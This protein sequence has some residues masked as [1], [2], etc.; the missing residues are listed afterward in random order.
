MRFLA[1]DTETTGLDVNTCEVIEL[2]F[3][4]YDTELSHEAPVIMRS[5]LILTKESLSKDIIEI[6]GIKPQTLECFGVH[7]E[8]AF[9]DLVNVI[10]TYR[11]QFIV[12]H[13]IIDYDLPIVKR[14][15]DFLKPH[16]QIEVFS[17]IVDTRVDLPHEAPPKNN[18]LIFLCADKAEFL[19]PFP[20]RALTDAMACMKLLF[21][22]PLEKVTQAA[23]SP[24]VEIRADVSFHNKDLAKKAGY[25]W[26]GDRKI[27]VKKIREI[28]LFEENKKYSFPV[29]MLGK[30][31]TPSLL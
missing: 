27:W 26:D 9:L 29:I 15:L 16:A 30:G 18:S 20:H 24:L 23:S 2:G 7:P 4:L 28:N 31:K 17:S 21:K 6:T 14:Y 10:N 5:H 22:F 3:A 13:N 1:L 12:G 19:N 11:P 8:E 25:N